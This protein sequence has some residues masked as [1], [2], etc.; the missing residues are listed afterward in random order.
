MPGTGDLRCDW[1]SHSL[2]LHDA[3]LG[4]VLPTGIYGAPVRCHFTE[5]HGCNE[6]VMNESGNSLAVRLM[7]LILEYTSKSTDKNC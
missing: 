3:E 6:E 1:C 4:L 2:K 5:L 7:N